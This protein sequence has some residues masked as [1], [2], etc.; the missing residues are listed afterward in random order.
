M[1]ARILD[2]VADIHKRF[3]K[4]AAT[5]WFRGHRST[6]WTLK[7]T[8]HRYI[9]EF[10]ERLDPPMS[11]EER[12]NYVREEAKSLYR[13]FKTD[14]WPLL[15]PEERSEW[16]VLLTMQ[17][18]RLPTRL[19]DWTESF[20]CALFFAHQRREVQQAAAV[21]VLV[22]E[23]LNEFAVGQRG[24]I[25]LNEHEGAVVIDTTEWHPHW[26]AP[27]RNLQSIAVAPI[28][29]NARMTA[30]RAA[31]TLMGDSFLPLEEQFDRRLTREGALIKIDLPAAEYEEVSRY[32]DVAGITAFTFYPD[33]EGLALKHEARVLTTLRQLQKFYPHRL[34]AQG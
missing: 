16:G 24:L 7:S 19:L 26:E 25:S 6:A 8:L 34:K 9:D 33:L 13:H 10:T 30:Q 22:P 18:Y 2:Q 21:W 4:D 29:T 1:L 28:F 11:H 15:R 12:R 32:L 20:A 14:A 27:D 23:R 31:F 3:A 17:H 5:A